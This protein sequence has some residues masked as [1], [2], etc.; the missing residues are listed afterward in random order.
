[1][2][3]ALWLGVAQCVS[4]GALFYSYGLVQPLLVREFGA[5]PVAVAGAFSL[6]LAI[7]GLTG[8][9][10]GRWID[11]GRERMVF[12]GGIGFGIA[13]LL[14]WAVADSTVGLYLA[15]M[16][17]GVAMAM[18][19][20]EPA[21]ALVDRWFDTTTD[22]NRALTIVTLCGALASPI[23][24]PIASIAIE[25]L[26]WRWMLVGAAGSLAATALIYRAVLAPARLRTLP[27]P[28]DPPPFGASLWWLGSGAFGSAF[29]GVLIS[30]FLPTYLALRG[31]SLA[32]AA[33]V[34][35]AMGLAQ[36]PA[37]AVMASLV[38]RWG[39]A[40]VFSISLAAQAIAMATIPTTRSLA[41]MTVAGAVFGA[42]NGAAT[43]L[44]AVAAREFT[45][46][47]GYGV[48]VGRLG[49]FALAARALAPVGGASLAVLGGATP[50]GVAAG[51]LLVTAVGNRF[52][53]ATRPG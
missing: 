41:V 24:V 29:G 7:S 42:G 13:A 52:A 50:F 37:R 43:I 22:K 17:A 12:F 15:M 36:F 28:A 10:V 38:T 32:V 11:H 40:R 1:M 30:A 45:G 35:S 49:A 46:G 3:R 51:L 21:F 31:D 39:V 44:R 18:T 4:W 48:T 6:A 34:I 27:T 2:G 19:L 33:T 14:G 16:V 8:L 20:Y 5:S 53:A 25:N 47:L 9:R 26:G 23:F